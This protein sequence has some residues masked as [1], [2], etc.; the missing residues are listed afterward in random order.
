MFVACGSP[1][2]MVA[3]AK[4]SADKVCACPDRD[5][6]VALKGE[7]EKVKAAMAKASDSVKAQLEEQLTRG[8]LCS[9]KIMTKK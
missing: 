8:N 4:A 1:D 5:C 2:P 9:I 7:K 3:E 6:V